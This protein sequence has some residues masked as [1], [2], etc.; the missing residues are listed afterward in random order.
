MNQPLTIQPS[1]IKHDELRKLTWPHARK[2]Q[3]QRVAGAALQPIDLRV[4]QEGE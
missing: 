3:L 1:S 4:C 2:R